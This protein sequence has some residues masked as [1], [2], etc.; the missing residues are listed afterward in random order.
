METTITTRGT[1]GMRHP[2]TGWAGQRAA[3][4]A[5]AAGLV[6]TALAGPDATP[7]AAQEPEP[8]RETAR[9][10]V[11]SGDCGAPWTALGIG[12]ISCTACSITWRGAEPSARFGT[13]PEL[14]PAN[15]SVADGDRVRAGDRLVAVDGE[16]ITTEAGAARLLGVR[17][18]D[19][20]GVT[21]RR[22][23]RTR[24]LEVVAGDPCD[25]EPPP[26][27]RTAPT[28]PPAEPEPSP[29]PTPSA[30]P[31]PTP[32]S[33]RAAPAPAPPSPTEVLPRARLGFA[34]TCRH[35][36]IG[37]DGW[38][39]TSPPTVTGVEPDG[40][41]AEAGFRTGDVLVAV[42]GHP[43]ASEAGQRAFST[44][45]PGDRVAWEVRRDGRVRELALTATE[46]PEGPDPAPPAPSTGRSAPPSP[47]RDVLRYQGRLGD[48]DVEVRGAPVTVVIDEESGEIVIRT[49]DGVVRLTRVNEGG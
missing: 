13:E 11:G 41:A 18:G 34:F 29:R 15:P 14:A 12:R 1:R 6:C 10:E 32:P 25:V 33:P 37:D 4:L 23:D 47:A 31:L 26:Q 22:D 24:E 43:I 49:S 21:V 2:A 30:D 35:C 17:P 20:V 46:K 8:S 40:P 19:T 42:G 39:F 27:P 5:V 28:A 44:I 38:V 36:G 9:V 48:T 7:A 3:S 45:E 16:L